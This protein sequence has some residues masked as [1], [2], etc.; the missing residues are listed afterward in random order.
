MSL[1]PFAQHPDAP[2]IFIGD[3]KQFGPVSVTS[4]DRTYKALFEVQRGCSLLK[5]VQ[6]RGALYV[7]DIKTVNKKNGYSSM[8]YRW[9]IDKYQRSHRQ[10]AEPATNMI[11]V[12]VVDG[13]ER[14]QNASYVNP[15]NAR[16]VT[17][18]VSR[19]VASAPMFSAESYMD[20]RFDV[21]RYKS[22]KGKDKAQDREDREERI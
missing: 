16:F 6:A 21:E 13:Q 20:D 12:D 22:K 9:V 14:K 18:L 19:L 8:I 2:V 11:F 7:S 15:T 3:T 5:R 10:T 1:V 4:T 17:E